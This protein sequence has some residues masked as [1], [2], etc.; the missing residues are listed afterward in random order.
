TQIV[1]GGQTRTFSYSSLSRLIS[2]TNP[3]SGTFTYRYDPNGNLL[4]KTDARGISTTYTYDGLNRVTFRNYSDSTPDIA[5]TYDDPAVPFSRG[6][7][8]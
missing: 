6:K 5:Y 8:T 7:L 1:Q 3:E 4:T 2:A